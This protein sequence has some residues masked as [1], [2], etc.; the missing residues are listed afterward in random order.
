[1]T[2]NHKKYS[3]R[4]CILDQKLIQ[5]LLS[6]GEYKDAE[7]FKQDGFIPLF[8]NALSTV[9]GQEAAAKRGRRKQFR[10]YS[11]SFWVEFPEARGQLG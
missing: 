1:M 4:Y 11:T 5:R 10:I 7:A 3:I 8:L 9:V 2:T 6:G